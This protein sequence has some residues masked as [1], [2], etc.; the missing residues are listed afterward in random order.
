MKRC[1]IQQ[2]AGLGDIIFCQKIAHKLIDTGY[3]VVWPVIPQY[4]WISYYLKSK[5]G[6]FFGKITDSWYGESKTV[7]LEQAGRLFPGMSFMDAK[8]YLMDMDYKDW[9]DYF[10]FK[11]YQDRE[12]LLMKH[13]PPKY[14]LVC[15][16]FASPP[17]EQKLTDIPIPQ[18]LPVVSIKTLPGLN[19]FDWCG[20]IENATN[21]YFV[22]TCF[23]Y[24]VEKLNIKAEKIILFSRNFGKENETP[25]YV[26]T[27]HLFSKPWKEVHT[28]GDL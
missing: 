9:A 17:L 13:L 6:L 5:P 18:D 10:E 27:R 1:I 4:E 25:T 7:P 19:P 12:S 22:D 20:V 21:L 2:P 15:D 24:I 14:T 3:D 16:T 26:A 23:T 8:Y 28:K 11:R